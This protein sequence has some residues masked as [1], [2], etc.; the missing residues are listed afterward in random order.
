MIRLEE[1]KST[2]R[3]GVKSREALITKFKRTSIELYIEMGEI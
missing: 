2:T 3:R 1:I